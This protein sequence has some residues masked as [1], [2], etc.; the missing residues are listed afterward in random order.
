MLTLYVS[1]WI[2]IGILGTIPLATLLG[3]SSREVWGGLLLVGVI[4]IV[5]LLDTLANRQLPRVRL[6]LTL[7]L[8]LVLL[9]T[10]TITSTYRYA[11]LVALLPY[12]AGAMLWAL[13]QRH[14]TGIRRLGIATWVM[15]GCGAIFAGHALTQ[16]PGL[17]NLEIGVSSTFGWKNALAGFLALVGPITV[18][19]IALRSKRWP[20]AAAALALTIILSA[21]FFTT[22]QAGWLALAVGIT[23]VLVGVWLIQGRLPLQL[24]GWVALAL[25]VSGAV[26]ALILHLNAVANPASGLAATSLERLAWGVPSSADARL[27]YWETSANIMAAF[28]ILGVGLGNFTT[29]YTHYFRQ[30]WLYTISPHNYL[31]YLAV[32]GGLTTAAVLVWFLTTRMWYA[33]RWL[34]RLRSS[35]R[36]PAE[37]LRLGWLAGAAGLLIHGLFDLSLEIPA[38]N[39]LW[40]L[41]LGIGIPAAV[42]ARAVTLSQGKNFLR[43]GVTLGLVMVTLLFLVADNRYQRALA[44]TSTLGRVQE[45]LALLRQSRQLMPLS[46]NT[47]EAMAAARWDAVLE[48]VGN[49]QENMRQAL[50]AALGAAELDPAS[51]HRQWFLGRVYFLTMTRQQ[52]AWPQVISH[53]EQAVRYDF[54][55][56]TYYRSLAEAYLRLGW[57][58]KARGTLDTALAL[59]PLNQLGK[60][61]AGA[62]VYQQFG[63][64]EKLEDLQRL[65]QLLPAEP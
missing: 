48:H 55:E 13:A 6:P 24:L 29:W 41:A 43:L 22:S 15:I 18:A 38:I 20:K 33:W 35:P 26:I 36:E 49:R 65:R 7:V 42:S 27:R 45:R 14:V 10:A 51:A 12:Y 54:H 52:P 23:T 9:T 2:W 30:P 8:F 21:L 57:T 53:L 31:I 3:W 4:F 62:A 5:G 59:Y 56:P 60:I 32:S 16:V 44:L 34:M 39:L 46:A 64:K 28:P 19:Q 37:L 50:A 11:S 25:A 1:R 40:F 47:A 17:N 63:L 58:Q 61:F